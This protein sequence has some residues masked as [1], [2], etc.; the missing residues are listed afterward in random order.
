MSGSKPQAFTSAPGWFVLDEGWS[1]EAN[2]N[3]E[4]GAW[5]GGEWVS[6]NR[7]VLGWV[8]D[9]GSISAL[10]A[11]GD[12]GDSTSLYLLSP[13]GG[14]SGPEDDIWESLEEWRKDAKSWPPAPVEVEGEDNAFRA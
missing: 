4:K 1:E 2:W 7:E 8:H 5:E 12:E 9:Q 13:N 10:T 11:R 14:V 6:N 3:P